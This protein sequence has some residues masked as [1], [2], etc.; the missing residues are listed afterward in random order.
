MNNKNIIKP[1]TVSGFVE[2]LPEEK[3]LE[4][5]MLSIIRK[6]FKIFGFSQIETPAVERVEVLTSKGGNEKEIYALRRLTAQSGDD[7]K[8]L[9][10]RFD[11]TVPLARYVA[12]HFYKLSFPFRCYQ[13]QKV[14]RGERPQAGRFREFYQCDID[15]IGDEKLDLLIDAEIISVIYRIFQE[16]KIGP[17]I[18]RINNRKIL[19]GY[20]QYIGINRNNWVKTMRIIDKLEKFGLEKVL[21]ELKSLGIENSK[22]KD[23]INFLSQNQEADQMM[24][25]LNTMRVN[26]LFSEGIQ[27]IASVVERVKFF[28]IPAEAFQVDLSIARGLDYYTST[29][30]ETNLVNYPA[31]GSICSGGRYN[32]LAGYFINRKLPGVGISIGITRLLSQLIKTGLLTQCSI[33]S[34]SVLVT[35][36][37]RNYIKTYVE[38]ATLL[39][40]AGV[41][42]EVYFEQKKINSQMKYANRKGFPAV[43]I[44]GDMELQKSRVQVKNMKTGEQKEVQFND[45]AYE[46]KK[47]I[48]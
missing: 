31:L 41:K 25:K 7:A 2:W 36:L 9:A 45:I 30:Y 13:I 6:N 43:V 37:D 34:E 47:I 5:K 24:R 46:V 40:N 19:Q 35:V 39:R 21:L 16:M 22:C 3:I 26:E 8:E 28:K 20:F 33:A 32:D 27:E 11:L 42:T 44:A 38:I 29:V 18:I 1:N 48:K 15:V 14:W 23:L 4:N 12:Q 10:L 17:F